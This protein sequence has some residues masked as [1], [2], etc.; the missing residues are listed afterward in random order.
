MLCTS[1]NPVAPDHHA[2]ARQQAARLLLFVKKEAGVDPE[3]WI[4]QDADNPYCESDRSRNELCQILCN[5]GRREREKLLYSDSRNKTR[6]ELA[7]WYVGHEVAVREVTVPR[8]QQRNSKSN[9]RRFGKRKFP[10]DELRVRK[11]ALTVKPPFE[12]R[13]ILKAR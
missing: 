10:R 3:P 6:R 8:K 11:D 12:D 1:S 9:E 2:Q 7:L 13:L 5:M 4:Q